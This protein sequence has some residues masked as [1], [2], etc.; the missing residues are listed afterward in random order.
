MPDLNYS[1]NKNKEFGVV[2]LP[3]QRR[4][5]PKHGTQMNGRP[6]LVVWSNLWS[7]EEAQGGQF[8]EKTKQTPS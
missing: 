4:D 2:W 8:G 6:S 1:A 3:L 7:E 5:R